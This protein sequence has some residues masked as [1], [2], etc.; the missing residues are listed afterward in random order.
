M[1]NPV[2]I[3]SD[4]AVPQHGLTA[5]PLLASDLPERARTRR[6][7]VLDER[8]NPSAGGARQGAPQATAA[9]YSA[10]ATGLLVYDLC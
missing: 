4:G 10:G 5:D 3:R 7:R 6:L 2:G 1:T 8:G 9:C